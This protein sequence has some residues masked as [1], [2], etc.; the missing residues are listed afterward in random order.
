MP[1][2]RAHERQHDHRPQHDARDRP[3]RRSER[4]PNPEL[5]R[6]LGDQM[7]DDRIQPRQ[8]HQPRNDG[9]DAHQPRNHPLLDELVIEIRV[10]RADVGERHARRQILHH[11]PHSRRSPGRRP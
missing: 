6:P 9:D 11:I 3:R 4:D 8:R 7:R 1:D 5:A 10:H 2:R